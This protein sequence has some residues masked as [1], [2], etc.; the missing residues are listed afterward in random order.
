VEV[1]LQ[2]FFSQAQSGAQI[3]IRARA[4]RKIAPS[5]DMT[6]ITETNPVALSETKPPAEAGLPAALTSP[7]RRR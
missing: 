6:P 4:L 1:R 7:R 3:G 5:I 2:E